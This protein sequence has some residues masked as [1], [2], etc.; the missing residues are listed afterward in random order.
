MSW[1]KNTS[2]IKIFPILLD[3]KLSQKLGTG[4]NQRRTGQEGVEPAET[5]GKGRESGG[6]EKR[7]VV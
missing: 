4:L 3:R 7:R 1:D 5:V 2:V 6:R